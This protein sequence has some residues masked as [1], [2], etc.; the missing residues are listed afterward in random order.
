MRA[1]E[2][3]R[4]VLGI[5]AVGASF[6]LLASLFS[7]DVQDD[8]TRVFPPNEQVSNLGGMTGFW[9]AKSIFEAVGVLG[10]Y[11][12]I[13]LILCLA[14]SM[15]GK[16]EPTKD[17]IQGVVGGVAV[18]LALSIV[19]RFFAGRTLFLIGEIGE[20]LN[21]RLA[22]GYWG[23]FLEHWL[24]KSFSTVGLIVVVA[25]GLSTGTAL[26]A[27]FFAEGW[28]R[29]GDE[30]DEETDEDELLAQGKE[31]TFTKEPQVQVKTREPLQVP[32]P[33]EV[34]SGEAQDEDGTVDIPLESVIVTPRVEKSAAAQPKESK[35]S[36]ESAKDE[37]KDEELVDKG[38]VK[39][40][41]KTREEDKDD[42]SSPESDD[43]EP[44]QPRFSAFKDRGGKVVKQAGKRM[45]DAARGMAGVAMKVVQDAR[46]RDGVDLHA[47]LRSQKDEPAPE[48]C[49]EA[50]LIVE[51]QTA[52]AV[53]DAPEEAESIDFFSEAG[54]VADDMF[55]FSEEG[56]DLLVALFE[57]EKETEKE[58]Q[59]ETEKTAVTE[60]KE[61]V[62]VEA[63]KAPEPVKKEAAPVVTFESVFGSVKK[64]TPKPVDKAKSTLAAV[65]EVANAVEKMASLAQKFGVIEDIEKLGQ[66]SDVKE[67]KSA[68]KTAMAEQV[69]EAVKPI[70]K[71]VKEAVKA[72]IEVQEEL[73]THE[74][75]SAPVLE[76]LKEEAKSGAELKTKEQ[77]VEAPKEEAPVKTVVD[78]KDLEAAKAAEVAKAVE[79]AIAVEVAKAVELA[80][81]NEIAKAVEIA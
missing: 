67:P 64:E 2:I 4:E 63:K 11:G 75:K 26:S 5:F 25:M 28:G 77:S 27:E 39:A 1:R 19:E 53:A 35:E 12:A 13:S 74:I 15:L 61:P 81:A 68:S 33:S 80:K 41:A 30:S 49:L 42:D 24:T 69:K 17:L 7:Y 65:A 51:T 45:W 6:F 38:S 47:E 21:G 54:T 50:E 78:A 18:I 73:E 29:D 58:A 10:G 32:Y 76:E 44:W 55:L 9:L 60:P 57:D 70:G 23:T 56:D 48:T 8:P 62:K 46:S 36:K 66:S 20:D 72:V 31:E 16:K 14:L 40:E 3:I 79:E 52:T 71:S 43:S 37:V 34:L 22:G 59:Q